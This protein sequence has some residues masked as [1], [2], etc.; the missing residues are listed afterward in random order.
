MRDVMRVAIGRQAFARMESEC[1]QDPKGVC[2]ATL[3]R[4]P[5]AWTLSTA[6]V[7]ECAGQE[8][9]LRQAETWSAPHP[10]PDIGEQV[11]IEYRREVVAFDA[12]APV[13][14]IKSAR[15]PNAAQMRALI[16]R[17][18]AK[19]DAS[20][21]VMEAIG[22][23]NVR[24]E[25]DCTMDRR[26]GWPVTAELRAIGAAEAMEGAEIVRFERMER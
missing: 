7:F 26:S 1:G 13:V 9:D 3:D 5:M 10:N 18:M 8:V 2:C 6:A 17:E 16:A 12:G 20:P 23:W 24:F 4:P 25:V 22:G 19:V 15:Q 21:A 11:A 14:R